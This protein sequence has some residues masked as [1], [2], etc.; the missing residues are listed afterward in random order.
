[1]VVVVVGGEL[2]ALGEGSVCGERER[3]A[4]GASP[5]QSEGRDSRRVACAVEGICKKRDSQLAVPPLCSLSRGR[6]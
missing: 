1:M 3:E 5:P 4:V 2:R 6:D